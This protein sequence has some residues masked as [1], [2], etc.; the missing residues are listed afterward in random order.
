LKVVAADSA[1]VVGKK[2]AF[3]LIDELWEFGKEPTPTR[4]CERRRA[5]RSLAMKAL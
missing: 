1:T 5:A 4:C 3:V 2:A